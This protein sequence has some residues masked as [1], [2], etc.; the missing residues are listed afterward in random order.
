MTDT[1]R[2][3]KEIIG[4]SLLLGFIIAFFPNLTGLDGHQILG[5]ALGSL[6][7]YHGWAHRAWIGSV[8]R[9]LATGPFG[10]G[11]LIWLLDA[12]LA[13]SF[14]AIVGTGLLISTWLALP[15]ATLS[16]WTNLHVLGSVA[17][18]GLVLV[19][20][21]THWRWFIRA[22]RPKV[23]VVA[24]KPVSARAAIPVRTGPTRREFLGLMG[25]L[26]VAAVAA[27]AS[28]LGGR[29]SFGTAV[30]QSG[31]TTTDSTAAGTAN[32]VSTA[33]ATATTSSTC[34]VLCNR[35]CS[36]P[37]QCRRYVD[38]NA[39]GRCDRGECL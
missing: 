14:A 19:K 12:A 18:L 6:A 15:V 21:A 8:A 34:T 23:T 36:F 1:S 28:A 16:L 38:A 11:K 13:V 24:A 20:V 5:T 35:G 25:A 30:A 31:S 39:N 4:S 26:G 27:G 3:L 10:R 17:T 37:G 7:A 9:R 29:Y 22:L 33:E 2:H 32:A